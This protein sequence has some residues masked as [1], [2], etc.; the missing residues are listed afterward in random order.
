MSSGRSIRLT[1]PDT[2]HEPA[3]R[4]AFPNA[5]IAFSRVPHWLSAAPSTSVFQSFMIA[6]RARVDAAWATAP[7]AV[8]V[9][10]SVNW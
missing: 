6:I 2:A 4:S 7:G 5:K 8:Q 1:R 10:Q 9:V 3:T